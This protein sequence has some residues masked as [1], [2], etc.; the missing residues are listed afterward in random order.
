MT[1]SPW[2]KRVQ[3]AKHLAGAH[4]A[5][6]EILEFYAE[7]A[8]LQAELYAR[9]TNGRWGLPRSEPLD[10]WN[11]RSSFAKF[12]E[13]VARRGTSQLKQAVADLKRR[14]EEKWGE[15]LSSYW[16]G[17][18]DQ[19]DPQQVFL[20]RSFLQPLAELSREQAPLSLKD[21]LNAA[22]PYCGW[23]PGVAILRPEGD[24]A[25]RSL[26]CSFCL[27]EWNFRRIVCPGC[28]EEDN[29]KL[30]VY[31]AEEFDCVRVEACD[32]CKQYI[33]SVD[34]TKNGLAEPVVDEIAAAALDLWAHEHGY[35]KLE[36]NLM[37]M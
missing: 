19:S 2:Q 34:L 15:A 37:G 18:Q 30:P 16:S 27:A 8:S 6:A 33:K 5:V 14:G 20:C 36:L 7:V 35:K 31:S 32:T 10:F 11:V 22:C 28:G 26:Q 9:F 4:P 17:G 3:R 12:L 25:K 21:Y 13:Q 23:R 29:H 24:G 1:Q